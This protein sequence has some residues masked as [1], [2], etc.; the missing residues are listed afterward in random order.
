VLSWMNCV[1]LVNLNSSW[2]DYINALLKIGYVKNSM[3][4]HDV[5]ICNVRFFTHRFKY[6]L[7]FKLVNVISSTLLP[8]TNN[9]NLNMHAIIYHIVL[10]FV[11]EINS[12]CSVITCINFSIFCVELA[13]V[14]VLS[15]LCTLT[16]VKL[17]HVEGIQWSHYIEQ[18]SS[19]NTSENKQIR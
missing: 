10:R 18:F 17:D 14:F 5:C 11:M 16:V 4:S 13:F 19:A 9:L 7:A 2:K 3:I 15:K 8:V 12:S 1:S 6:T